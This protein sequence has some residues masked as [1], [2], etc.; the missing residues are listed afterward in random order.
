MNFLIDLGH[1]IHA[2][3][4]PTRTNIQGS[5]SF[6][7]RTAGIAVDRHRIGTG[8]PSIL[9]KLTTVK[10]TGVRPRSKRLSGLRLV[11]CVSG[12]WEQ[13]SPIR[14]RGARLKG[15]LP[16]FYGKAGLIQRPVQLVLVT[17]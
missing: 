12:V 4:L 7:P 1:D 3:A 2:G 16:A 10:S 15:H 5:D 9:P 13:A 17:L 11:S 6:G 14:I 8:M